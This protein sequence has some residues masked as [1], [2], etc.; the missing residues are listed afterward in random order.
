MTHDEFEKFQNRLF[1]AFPNI[2]GWIKTNSPAPAQTLA[3][4]EQTLLP[5]RLDECL[6]ILAEWIDGKRQPPTPYE[7]HS[8]PLQIRGRVMFERDRDAKKDRQSRDLE[9]YEDHRR[10]AERHRRGYVPLP[11]IGEQGSMLHAVRAGLELKKRYLGGKLTTEEYESQ[12]D[13]IVAKVQ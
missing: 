8:T 4:W 13:A 3:T 5:C 2:W 10:A 9:S 12:L 11:A 6:T 7:Y 1:I